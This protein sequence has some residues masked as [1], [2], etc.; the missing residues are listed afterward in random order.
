MRS[1]R[2]AMTVFI[3][4]IIIAIGITLTTISIVIAGKAV[5]M[6]SMGNMDTLVDNVA[7]YADLKLESDLI[8]LRTIAEFPVVKEDGSLQNQAMQLSQYLKNVGKNAR[9]FVLA[10][11][12]GHAY[13]SEGVERDIVRRE[14]FQNACNG[15]EVVSGPILSAKG[16]PSIYASVPVKGYDGKIKGVLAVNIDTGILKDFAAQMS[17]SENGKSVI[18]DR[19]S[20]AILCSDIEEYVKNAET[21]EHLAQTS[22]SGLVNFAAVTKKMQAG[23]HGCELIKIYGKDYYVA[24]TSMKKADW[25][26]AIDAPRS[27]FAGSVS[28]LAELLSISC[29]IFAVVSIV[30]GFIF[31]TSLSRPINLIYRVLD[32]VANG[33]LILDK[34]DDERRKKLLTRKDELG[35]MGKSLQ[36]MLESLTATIQHVREAAIQVRSGGEQL[37]ISSQSVSSG[38]SEQAASTEEMSATMEEMTGNIRQTAN[39]AG[40]TSEIAN[41]AAAK[42]E[43]GG[44]AVQ[45]AVKAVEMISEK[46]GVIEDIAGQTNMLALNAAIEAARA[47]EAGKGFAVVASE[48]RKLAERSQS[49]AAEIS[50]ISA[51]TLSTAEHAGAMIKEVVPGIEQT[52]QLVQEIATASREQDNGAQQVSTAIVQMDSV[53]QQNASAAEEMAAMAEE[54]SSEA[55]RLVKVISFFKVD[56]DPNADSA[57]IEAK[58]VDKVPEKPVSVAEKKV[59]TKANESP[60]E[61]PAVKKVEKLNI[62]KIE[63]AEKVEEKPESKKTS[64]PQKMQI[65]KVP[66]KQAEAQ[67]ASGNAAKSESGSAP[68]SGSVTRKTTADLIS[69]ADFEEF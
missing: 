65:K 16:E 30:I 8:A 4:L 64:K 18:I 61:T 56:G 12:S 54:L 51:K 57:D 47:G 20:G 2:S 52:S 67:P 66:E 10:D 1:I 28:F 25:A 40:K 38:A 17:I 55:Q 22:Q 49:A 7:S 3:S 50:D 46:I 32:S 53:V 36:K 23:Q 24:Y 26:L 48:V 60:A 21:F 6:G 44:E 15:K 39:N 34:N 63:Q 35:K 29:V 27:D 31:A 59:E 5:D 58:P 9:Y 42:A 43:A 19:A 41:M 68:V 69:D 14:Y 13:T 45:E 11:S 62:K 37:S 33:N